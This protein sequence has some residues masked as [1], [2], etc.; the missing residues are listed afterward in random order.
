[1]SQIVI[2]NKD[3]NEKL[4]SWELKWSLKGNMLHLEEKGEKYEEQRN[5]R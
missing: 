3:F 2:S 4:A 5:I 1:M